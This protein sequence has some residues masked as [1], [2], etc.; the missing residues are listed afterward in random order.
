[1]TFTLEQDIYPRLI[2]AYNKD[3]GK[4]TYSVRTSTIWPEYRPKNGGINFDLESVRHFNDLITDGIQHGAFSSKLDRKEGVYKSISATDTQIQNMA[5]RL[6]IDLK[7][8]FLRAMQSVLEQYLYS[9][10]PQVSTWVA[11]QLTQS[12]EGLLQRGWFSFTGINTQACTEELSTLLNGCEKAYALEEDVLQRAFSVQY[13]NGSKDFQSNYSRKLATIMEP[14]LAANDVSVQDILQKL[15]ILQN[16]A[17]VWLKGS[18]QIAFSNKDSLTCDAYS[19]SIALTR[20]YVEQIRH[21]QTRHILTIENL[22]TFQEITP[23]AET[24]VVFTSG[25][26]NGLVVSLLRK[27]LADNRITSLCHF[28]DLDAFG[29]H[30]LQNLSARLGVSVL[31]YRMDQQTFLLHK[32]T[33]VEMTDGNRKLFQRLLEDPYWSEADKQFFHFLL[34]EGRTLEQESIHNF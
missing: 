26:A 25:Y 28:G 19:S 24:L 11:Q 10:C 20:D 9:S 30:I 23:P 34:E 18:T 21:I 3:P 27:A 14:E 6:G 13:F 15:H 33:S 5:H 17:S 22:T 31:P 8:D 1:M 2:D 29:F 32:N 16:P 4:L 7:P 12:G